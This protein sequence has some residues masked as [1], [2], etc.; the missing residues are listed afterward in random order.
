MYTGIVTERG[1]STMALPKTFVVSRE[2]IV[3]LEQWFC[4]LLGIACMASGAWGICMRPSDGLIPAG[5]TS[6]G[7]AYVPALRVTAI[8]CLGMGVALLR[9]GS[10]KTLPKS[11]LPSLKLTI[12]TRSPETRRGIREDSQVARRCVTSQ[13]ESKRTKPDRAFQMKA[14]GNEGELSR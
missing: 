7:S 9:L 2:T 8:A 1:G 13:P 14:G 3:A 5:L 12:K 10:A 6:L 4:F 11:E